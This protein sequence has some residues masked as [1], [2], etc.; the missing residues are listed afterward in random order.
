MKYSDSV[1][2]ILVIA[3]K[4]VALSSP[5]LVKEKASIIG[6]VHLAAAAC[7]TGVLDIALRRLLGLAATDIVWPESTQNLAAKLATQPAITVPLCPNSELE[8]LFQ[9][10]KRSAPDAILELDD[11]ALTIL[12]GASQEWRS[13]FCTR[14]GLRE[15]AHLMPG[16]ET[17][18]TSEPAS[19][20]PPNELVQLFDKVDSFSLRMKQTVFG[21]DH[22]VDEV[23]QALLHAGL[24]HSRG[25]K[26][27]VLFVGP[28]GCGKTHMA[29]AL[30][31][32]VFEGR[33]KRFDMSAYSE[34][35]S[36]VEGLIGIPAF[37]Q[38]SKQQPGELTTYVMN[39]PDTLLIFDEIEKAAPAVI[40]LFL[41]ILD[42]GS[43][44]DKCSG[45]K[46]DFSNTTVLFTT[47]A[48]R[49]L[50]DDANRTGLLCDA[51]KMYRDTILDALEKERDSS[52]NALFPPEICSRLA[53]G[54]PVL[55]RSLEPLDYERILDLEWVKFNNGLLGQH[56]IPVICED[57]VVKA[58][59]VLNSGPDLD[60]RRVRNIAARFVT[61]SLLAAKRSIYHSD[62]MKALLSKQ[63]NQ[64]LLRVSPSRE[65]QYKDLDGE[66]DTGSDGKKIIESIQEGA[67]RILLVDDQQEGLVNLFRTSFPEYEWYGATDTSS[68]C[69]ILRAHKVDW[70]LQDLDLEGGSDNDMN[71]EPGIRCLT[72]L[73]KQWPSLP[74][75]IFSRA[76]QSDCFDQELYGRC[77]KAG[78][79]RGYIE[80]IFTTS[81]QTQ[82]AEEF[83]ARLDEVR[84]N[85]AREAVVKLMLRSRKRVVFDIIPRFHETSGSIH[86]NIHNVRYETVP[87][88]SAY[89]LFQIVRPETRLIDVAGNEAAMKELRRIV[90]WLRNSDRFERLGASIPRGV[91][92]VGPPGTGKTLLA[93]A[94]AGEADV[95]FVAVKAP[96]FKTSFQA[97]AATAIRDLFA[98][99]RKHAPIII[100]IDEI[101]AIAPRR[102]LTV[103]G[104]V[105]QALTQLLVEMDGF[106]SFPSVLPIVV[107]AATN[108]ADDIDDALKRPG[109]FDRVVEVGLPD[110][111]ARENILRLH[112]KNKGIGE[113]NWHRLAQRTVGRSGA[114]LHRLVQ[115]ALILATEAGKDV[116]GEEDFNESVTRLEMGS[117]DE[118]GDKSKQDKV[119]VSAHEA[120]HAVVMKTLFPSR[121]IPQITVIGRRSAG[122][123][124][125]WTK[126]EDERK[127]PDRS[128]LLAD[129]TVQLG[130]RAA[131]EV[132]CNALTPGASEDLRAATS[133]AFRMVA[134]WGLSETLGLVSVA[135]LSGHTSERRQSAIEDDMQRILEDCA[136]RARRIIKNNRDITGKLQTHL[137]KKETI[138]EEEIDRFWTENGY[139]DEVREDNIR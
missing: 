129:I 86:C 91:L 14:N 39:N 4:A 74:V 80:K 26:A 61:E 95:P 83:K 33:Y 125:E 70:V 112:A 84:N 58:L 130:G 64:M 113:I 69:E 48:G 18:R 15:P 2:E 124:M 133:L 67:R 68:A 102:D 72:V 34:R 45:Q 65:G 87:T 32:L 37:Y 7:A 89:S 23:A 126:S 53:G 139:P 27:V 136:E 77:V 96:E 21:Q 73:H 59:L 79:A 108:R 43:L 71:V 114:D 111:T 132:L 40:R 9:K 24:V 66:N 115:E 30:G 63:A 98:N 11:L 41:Q 107:L 56:G 49:S 104:E 1:R 75:F 82:E 92:M 118:G 28:P 5:E 90:E 38:G 6:W 105:R 101:D 22:A 100:F 54:Y 120:G 46:V 8:A 85:L 10:V 62:V 25:P 51:P 50:Y 42:A 44:D 103:D 128:A 55:F 17:A 94:V 121:P 19:P 31:E 116:A 29:L 97:S 81:S 35:Q 78:G 138:L 16:G 117:A 135:G 131:E 110:V 60:A 76:L 57:P 93:R 119:L 88:S 106:S 3:K 13:D 99:A 127:C 134:G 122:G 109:R 137:E 52:G 36:G 20:A 47:N 123:F 12:D